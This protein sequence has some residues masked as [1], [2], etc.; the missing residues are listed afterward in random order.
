MVR[1]KIDAIDELYLNVNDLLLVLMK[2]ALHK[3]LTDIQR[4]AY[5]SIIK[6]IET[7]RGK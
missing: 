7:I 6:T 5:K 1:T 3:D 4:E 2:Q